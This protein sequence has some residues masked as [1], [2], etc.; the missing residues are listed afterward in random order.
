[1]I[2]IFVGFAALVLAAPLLL[3]GCGVAQQLR[4]EDAFRRQMDIDARNCRAGDNNAFTAYRIDV[5]RCGVTNQL[6]R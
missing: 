2:R 4:E 3:S 5:Q 6:C 1:M